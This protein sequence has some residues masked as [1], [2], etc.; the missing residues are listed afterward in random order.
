VYEEHCAVCHEAPEEGS[1]AAPIGVLRKMSAQTLMTALTTGV[2]KPVGE[3][4]D[5]RQMRD[6][7]AYLAAPEGP[8][9]TAWIDAARCPTERAAVDLTAAPAQVGFGVDTD[10]SR[11]MN[12]RQAGLTTA[13][14]ARLEVAWAFAMPRTSGLRG[15]GVVVGNT[16]FYPA[17]QAGHIL[18]LDTKT[19]K[20]ATA[21]PTA[22]SARTGPWASSAGKALAT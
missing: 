18:A 5:R 6:V 11:R 3:T 4:L 10:N 2:M 1:R 9:G 7:V 20:C 8:A 12:A 17:G 19:G 13:Q 21:W 14:A 22:A 16:L 15:Q